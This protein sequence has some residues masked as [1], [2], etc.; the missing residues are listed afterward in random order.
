M[1]LFR[2]FF[3][4]VLTHTFHC[5]VCL[6]RSDDVIF[7][8][9][10]AALFKPITNANVV[11]PIFSLTRC[12]WP[13][14]PIKKPD[15]FFCRIRILF[16]NARKLSVK[17]AKES[18]MQFTSMDHTGVLTNIHF[19]V[20]T[21]THFNW[22]NLQ[23]NNPFLSALTKILQLFRGCRWCWHTLCIT[24]CV[25]RGDDVILDGYTSWICRY[26]PCFFKPIWCRAPHILSNQM[27]A[28][29]CA[30]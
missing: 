27:C 15:S 5:C 26:W 13:S 17:W 21:K 7:D 25:C 16:F 23:K 14:V 1:Q 12:V 30:N 28:T 10:M 19:K 18:I 20:S 4:P 2:V 3:L 11:H 22:R 6:C 8:R 24:V 29:I 9:N